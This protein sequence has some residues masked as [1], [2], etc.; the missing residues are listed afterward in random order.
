ML[1]KVSEMSSFTGTQNNS[2]IES[3]APHLVICC[4]CCRTK[5]A[6]ESSTIASLEVPR[7]HCSRCDTV[8]LMQEP[9]EIPSRGAA[10]GVDSGSARWV[11]ADPAKTIEN[12]DSVPAP[13]PAPALR[14]NEFSI[15]I[16]RWEAEPSPQEAT[17][18]PTMKPQNTPTESISM[19]SGLSLLDQGQTNLDSQ[20]PA[21][22][23]A[24]STAP[25]TQLPS[26]KVN[27]RAE[28]P[29]RSSSSAAVIPEP[30]SLSEEN[31]DLLA[32]MGR[33][34]ETGILRRLAQRLSPRSRG[35]IKLAV[36][37]LASLMVLLLVSYSARISPRS[38]G[39]LLE[40]VTPST[41][42]DI[43]PQLPP[44]DLTIRDLSLRFVR[45][46]SRE[47]V[48]VV[49]GKLFNA[50]SKAIQDVTL[51]A[52][53]F[54][55]RGETVIAAKAPLRSALGNE[56]VS[57]LERETI[58]KFQHALGAKD[59]SIAAGESVPF[60]VALLTPNDANESS[61]GNSARLPTVKFFS[62]RIFSVR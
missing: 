51:E 7:F 1:P 32:K 22:G 21:G 53:G 50:S 55:E 10:Q 17:P 49:S 44:N 12:E 54:N 9:A 18:P 62:A 48:A 42:S 47:T 36:P 33:D 40:L 61:E 3:S 56:K 57:D 28:N 15:G 6:V 38:T 43:V 2:L 59:S 26:A 37:P 30:A 31:Q 13:T 25:R 8:F 23:F 58:V 45:T 14:P 60:S 16:G 35:L 20:R 41:I 46:P 39:S 52:R 34:A 29:L 19:R 5:F 11:L 27:H 24:A 4:P